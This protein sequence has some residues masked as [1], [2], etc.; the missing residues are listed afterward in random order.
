MPAAGAWRSTTPISIQTGRGRAD[1]RVRQRPESGGADA[2]LRPARRRPAA[3]GDHRVHARVGEVAQ[4]LLLCARS[5][6][7]RWPSA[8]SLLAQGA[9]PEEETTSTIT[10]R[11]R[12]REE[13]PQLAPRR[14]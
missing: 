9:S 7:R 10:E 5:D 6:S 8:L 12:A 1:R 3:R 4:P 11:V 13:A 14:A 2:G